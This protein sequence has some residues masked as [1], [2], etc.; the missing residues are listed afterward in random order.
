MKIHVFVFCLYNKTNLSTELG[1]PGAFFKGNRNKFI[2]NNKGKKKESIINL[3]SFVFFS[4]GY[5]SSRFLRLG[6]W[7]FPDLLF[8]NSLINFL[9]I[10]NLN[11]LGPH[12]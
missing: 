1:G 8:G 4:I 12:L 6:T 7:G 9:V 10:K 2:Q 5:C 11:S 3:N